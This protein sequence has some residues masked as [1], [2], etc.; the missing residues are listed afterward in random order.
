MLVK[1]R[2]AYEK[3]KRLEE[4]IDVPELMKEMDMKRIK[5]QGMGSERMSL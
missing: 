4:S 3:G 1:K 5:I 2:E